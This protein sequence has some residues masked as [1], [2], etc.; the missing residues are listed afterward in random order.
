MCQQPDDPEAPRDFVQCDKCQ[1]WF[2]PECVNTTT[3][4]RLL[5]PS[6]AQHISPEKRYRARP[7]RMILTTVYL[8]AILSLVGY[9]WVSLGNKDCCI[10]LRM[11]L[12]SLCTL[13]P[14]P[15]IHV[16]SAYAM[17]PLQA[18]HDMEM[19]ACPLCTR[20]RG[21]LRTAALRSAPAKFDPE[22]AADTRTPQEEGLPREADLP[23]SARGRHADVDASA[24]LPTTGLKLRLPASTQ[25]CKQS[26]GSVWAVVGGS[27]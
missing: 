18:V 8:P 7:Y 26:V 5:P 20:R 15:Q 2:H 9:S 21:G 24:A 22:A 23:R 25:V 3:Q 10:F 17:A 11:G 19:W 12:T 16:T 27:S 13:H 4:V 14:W 6:S 1:Q